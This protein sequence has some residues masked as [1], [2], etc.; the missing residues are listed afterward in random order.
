MTVI[1]SLT[2]NELYTADMQSLWNDQINVI[3]S[4]HLDAFRRNG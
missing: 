2:L 4:V 1:R 3:D